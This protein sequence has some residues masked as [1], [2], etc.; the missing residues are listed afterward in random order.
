MFWKFASFSGN[1]PPLPL[2]LL[3]FRIPCYYFIDIINKFIE[4]IT[5]NHY[6]YSA[7]P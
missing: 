2:E 4:K 7:L 5:D 1:T 6:A 3:G